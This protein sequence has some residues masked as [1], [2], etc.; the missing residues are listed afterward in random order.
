MKYKRMVHDKS[1]IN[2]VEVNELEI[3]VILDYCDIYKLHFQFGVS[4]LLKKQLIHR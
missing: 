4:E 3:V 2:I 1:I